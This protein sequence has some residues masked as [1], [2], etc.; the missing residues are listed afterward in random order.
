MTGND[1]KA[2]V[3]AIRQSKASVTAKEQLATD[4][5]RGLQSIYPR[6]KVE[7]FAKECGVA[8]KKSRKVAKATA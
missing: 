8:K 2:I 5:A 1:R 6:F 3:S 4:I 7:E